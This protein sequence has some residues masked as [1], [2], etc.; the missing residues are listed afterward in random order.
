MERLG[1]VS[2][3]DQVHVIDR[4]EVG[5]VAAIVPL[6]LINTSDVAVDE[7]HVNELADS[8]VKETAE[9]V[10]YGQLAAI[11]LGEVYGR[12]KFEIIDGFH[13]TS[14]LLKLGKNEALASIKTNCTEEEILD[15]R[16]VSAAT[17][18]SVHFA[19][20]AEWINDAWIHTPWHEKVT[21]SQAF[22]LAYGRSIRGQQ[23]TGRR[24][25]LAEQEIEEISDWVNVKCSGWS[26]SAGK[27]YT[28][29]KA[30][31][32]LDPQLVKE[33]RSWRGRE[34][35]HLS[36]QH[37]IELGRLLPGNFELQRL[38]VETAQDEK[39]DAIGTGALALTIRDAANV[40]EAKTL[41]E[42]GEYKLIR[43]TFQRTTRLGELA[44]MEQTD[45]YKSLLDS[46]FQNE[47][48]IARFSIE[49]AVLTG[50]YSPSDS[51][52]EEQE[53]EV[54]RSDVSAIEEPV[55]ELVPQSISVSAPKAQ[56]SERETEAIIVQMEALKPNLLN[57]LK[58]KFGVSS[59]DGEDII[60]E[61]ELRMYAAMTKGKIE[62]RGRQATEVYI[63]SIT[64]NLTI[65][66]WMS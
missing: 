51:S 17:H 16:I 53:I 36:P 27:I 2:L 54:E 46:W 34:R 19:R 32:R 64:R 22:S 18:R 40:D 26:M 38:A 59:Y 29:L 28:S 14:A 9:G 5:K 4:R 55:E 30:A 10:P 11:I 43:E 8:I 50:R 12:D 41:I 31:E 66:K 33:A 61:A 23:R 6:S 24:L 65:D 48:E 58:N 39:L 13:R 35:W 7:Y 25:D 56:L 57:Y 60:Q 44:K 62:Y 3:L 63:Y 47:M 1:Q 15:L 42:S 37:L 21:S 20:I 45:S 52:K 49:N